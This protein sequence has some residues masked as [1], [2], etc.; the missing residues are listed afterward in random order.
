MDLKICFLASAK[1]IHSYRWIKYFSEKRY[2]VDWISLKPCDFKKLENAG[3][4]LTKSFP[5]KF[6]NILFNIIPLR[7]ILRKTKPNILHAHYAG[8]EGVLGALSGFHPF[9]LTAWGSDVLIVPKSSKFA[10]FLIKFALKRAD[11]VTCDAEH[12]KKA[13]MSL[14]VSS[15]KIRIIYFGVDT[16]RFQPGPKNEK[17]VKEFNL[18]NSPVVISLRNLEPVYDVETLIRAVPLVLK[19]FP[20]AKFIVAGKGEEEKEL[21]ELTVSLGIEK[22]VK[23]V[24]FILN[25]ELP[26][27]LRIAD[28]YVSTS[29][30]DAGIASS[31]AEAMACG[32]PVVITNTGENEKWVKEGRGGYLIPTKNPT[33]LA[34]TIKKLLKNYELRKE[35]GDFNEK[36]IKERNDYQGE[37]AKMEKI[38]EEI[39]KNNKENIG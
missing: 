17:L 35:F 28:I 25:E 10:G 30:S 9:I 32:L 29:L 12:M 31:T 34:E 6:L 5:F 14:G 36:V 8:V 27:Y 26:D 38:Y 20:A 7:K 19:D 4:Y 16:K 11:L 1:S 15:S 2:V 13:L 23:F 3:F 39:F 18:E 33:V 24:G 22:S 37:M 21:K